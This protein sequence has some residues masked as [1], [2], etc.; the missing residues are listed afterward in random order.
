MSN[1]L[2]TS[3]IVNYHQKLKGNWMKRRIRKKKIYRI[4]LN[5][6]R[7]FITKITNDIDTLVNKFAITVNKKGIKSEGVGN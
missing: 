6:P 4:I 1:K 3:V 2:C 7:F 5:S